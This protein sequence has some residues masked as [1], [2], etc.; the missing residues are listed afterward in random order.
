[1]YCQLFRD[2]TGPVLGTE[3][4]IQEG[5]EGIWGE[6]GWDWDLTHCLRRKIDVGIELE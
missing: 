4:C 6:L 3:D 2:N 1:M 5:D